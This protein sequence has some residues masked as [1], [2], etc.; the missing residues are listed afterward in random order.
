MA[1]DRLYI[2][3]WDEGNNQFTYQQPFGRH[4]RYIHQMD[5]H[6][7][8]RHA[9][10]YLERKW[11]I[12]FWPDCSFACYLA[13]SEVNTSLV[14]GH[15]NMD[16]V[17]QPTLYF[18]NALALKCLE[19]TIEV[20]LGEKGKQKRTSKITIYFASKKITAKTWQNTGS[21]QKK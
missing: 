19:N 8:W 20:E 15:F 11:A 18:C 5:Y 14:S 9:P 2:H 17:V 4:F 7:N 21:K 12:K 6:N 16:G 1:K 10:I 3:Q 13:V